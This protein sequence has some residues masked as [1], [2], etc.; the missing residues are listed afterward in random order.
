MFIEIV[1]ASNL[2][3]ATVP[4]CGDEQYPHF[5]RPLQSIDFDTYG[6]PPRVAL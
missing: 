4:G 5:V 2:F 3:E 6:A 1:V